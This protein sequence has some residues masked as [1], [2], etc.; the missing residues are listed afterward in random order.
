MPSAEQRQCLGIAEIVPRRRLPVPPNFPEFVVKNT[1]EFL[2]GFQPSGWKR[3]RVLSPPAATFPV[4]ETV[5]VRVRLGRR[6]PRWWCTDKSPATAGTTHPENPRRHSASS[7]WPANGPSG[8][9]AR[10]RPDRHQRTQPAAPRARPGRP[11]HL[12][13]TW[14]AAWR[15]S[16]ATYAT[17]GARRRLRAL[18]R[19]RGLQE[20][21]VLEIAP[22]GAGSAHGFHRRVAW[23]ASPAART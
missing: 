5:A 7:F 12:L 9:S 16:P 4:G 14:S 10:S 6:K 13:A 23:A 15:H 18:V 22:P 20:R 8:S 19:H 21:V 17:V 1:R 3:R 2:A 11:T